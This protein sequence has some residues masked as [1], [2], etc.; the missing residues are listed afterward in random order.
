MNSFS[1]SQCKRF[2][3]VWKNLFFYSPI[4]AGLFLLVLSGCSTTAGGRA[5]RCT[6]EG[7]L[8]ADG[9]DDGQNCGWYLYEDD[10]LTGSASISGGKLELISREPGQFWWSNPGIDTADV[11]LT[12][13]TRKL[14][15]PD[16]NAFGLLCRYQDP[17]N[18]YLF[19]VSADGYY[20]IGKVQSG[21]DEIIY[22]TG[23]GEYQF[24]ELIQQG[25][26]ENTLRA[27]CEG[28]QLSLT[29]N[30]ILLDT[31]TD[32]TF[33]SGDIGVGLTAFEEGTAVVEFD[34]LRAIAP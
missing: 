16:D 8:L 31:A 21:V 24:S 9:F 17:N 10:S 15:G 28:S 11:T 12:V 1:L 26:Q 23:E 33:R 3:Q 30:G 25:V 5:T 20:A 14:N 18:F 34:D 6:P 13:T 19:L 32:D 4:L 7:V 2:K 27:T 29:V 22:L